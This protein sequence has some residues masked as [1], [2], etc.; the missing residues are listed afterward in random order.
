[1]PIIPASSD[2]F[3]RST[4]LIGKLVLYNGQQHLLLGLTEG[5]S[6]E[7]QATLLNFGKKVPCSALQP[8][9]Q[10]NQK[11]PADK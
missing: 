4:A 1:M 9:D 8:V 11:S 10:T 2:L 7:C 6:Q 5:P 3:A